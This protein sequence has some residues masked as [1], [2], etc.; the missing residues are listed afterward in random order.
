MDSLA[1]SLSSIALKTSAVHTIAELYEQVVD[2]HSTSELLRTTGWSRGYLQRLLREGHIPVKAEEFG[3]RAAGE[4]GRNRAFSW[5][6]VV[7]A[8]VIAWCTK[9][10]IP[11]KDAADAAMSFAYVGDPF[12]GWGDGPHTAV[13]NPS[14]LYSKGT[15]LLLFQRRVDGGYAHCLTNK[16]L[17]VQARELSWCFQSPADGRLDP[18]SIIVLWLDEPM[19]R[20]AKSMGLPLSALYAAGRHESWGAND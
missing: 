11:V 7:C 1:L 8:N 4:E 9:L 10:G 5:H 13:R 17:T 15:T 20:L 12:G 19:E 16:P 2:M 6:T 14:Q 3:D 18:D